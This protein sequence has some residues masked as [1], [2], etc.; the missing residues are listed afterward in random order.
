VATVLFLIRV[1][2][3]LFAASMLEC[4]FLIA[5]THLFQQRVET[6]QDGAL[7]RFSEMQSMRL[8]LPEDRPVA[9]GRDRGC[10]QWPEHPDPGATFFA[11]A[12]NVLP[13]TDDQK[14]SLNR[15]FHSSGAFHSCDPS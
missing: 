1:Y 9:Y 6:D 2:L 15:N 5:R 7:R 11:P 12:F 14:L 4:V 3:R 10:L 13:A 8:D